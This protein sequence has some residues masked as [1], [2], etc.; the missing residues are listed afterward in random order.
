MVYI[1]DKANN[2]VRAVDLAR[3]PVRI[4]GVRLRPG[5]IATVA[6]TGTQGFQDGPLTSSTFNHPAGLVDD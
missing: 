1:S 4:G 2:A 3:H 6:G 5:E